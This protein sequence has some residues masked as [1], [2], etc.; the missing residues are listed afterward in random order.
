MDKLLV[1]NWGEIAVRVMRAA[2]E[3]GL[4]TVAVY[5]P[6]DRE[7]LHRT[8][9]R[10]SY[11]LG[12]PGHPVRGYLDVAALIEVARRCGAD[13]LHPG[14]GFLSESAALAQ[15][16]A[17]AGIVFVGPPAEVLRLTGDKVSARDA[18]V[19]A[20][21]P[22]LRASAPLADGEGGDA[23]AEEVGFPLFV[24]AS[25]GGGGRGLR[26]VT[27]RAGLAEAVQSASREAAAAF[28]DGTVFL[29]Q[30]VTSPRH[31]EVQV[32]GDVTGDVVHLFE[33]D[34]SVQRRH[35][36]VVEL[37]PAPG[38]AGD[39]RA[40]LCDAA[41][42]FAR[43][44]GYVNAGTVEFLVD[45]EGAFTFMEMNP[46]IQV[47]HTVTEEVTGVDIVASQIHIA[48]G[49]SLAD[50]GLRQD[51]ISVRGV[52]VQCRIT[53]EDPSDDFRPGTGTI[54]SYQSPG[55]PGVRLDGAVYAGAQI[56]PYFDSLLVKL[57]TRGPDLQTAALRAQR[58]LREFR[59]RG[60]G[61]NADFLRRLL[62]DPAFLAG[63]VT[64][65]FLTERP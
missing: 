48:A 35:Q 40:G 65:S 30:A 44:V 2:H 25:A 34:C 20:G 58:A 3:L 61:T 9:A 38:L 24:K 27:D 8:K 42:A 52:A 55:G 19:R 60:V 15:A 7:A 45:A 22:V 12:E 14:Y 37:A 11:Q 21:L 4:A 51:S 26:V 28:G 54:T 56:T 49:R 33:R 46:R 64:T 31:I 47:E 59:V 50:L 6:E 5:T 39:V 32:L 16:C 13:A 57:T 29:E 23:D 1:A 63:G 17:D 18:A 10:E 36:K 53:T 43:S 41:V 62:S